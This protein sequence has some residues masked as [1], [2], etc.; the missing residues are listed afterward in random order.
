MSR[1][2]LKQQI[3]KLL[4]D[5]SGYEHVFY[6]EGSYKIKESGRLTE[7]SSKQAEMF[8]RAGSTLVHII[9]DTR[10]WDDKQQAFIGPQ[11]VHEAL[12]EVPEGA[13]VIRLTCCFPAEKA[14]HIFEM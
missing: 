14:T 9:E 12:P 8:M 5:A 3:D 2:I 1:A 10:R 4:A 6:Y 11:P 13:E 7:I